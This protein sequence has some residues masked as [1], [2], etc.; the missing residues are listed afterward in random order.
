MTPLATTIV[1]VMGVI[2]S[3]VTAVATFLKT[4]NDRKNGI[5]EHELSTSRFG[6]EAIQA[7]VAVKDTLINQLRE[8]VDEERQTIKSL[9]EE[10]E[11]LRM[12]IEVLN[13][14]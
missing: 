3:V 6:L 12:E 9:R 10:I 13:E 1:S 5:H 8:T 2:V 11:E 14:R 4:M 7:S